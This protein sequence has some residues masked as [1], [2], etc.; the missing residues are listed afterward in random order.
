MADRYAT[1]D[2]DW[3]DASVWDG[4]ASL[5]GAGDTVRPN[6]FD[7][8]IDQSITVG[9][10]TNNASGAAAANGT[11]TLADGITINA[12]I[13]PNGTLGGANDFLISDTGDQII[14]GDFVNDGSNIYD[15]RGLYKNTTG[16][17]TVNGD[18]VGGRG[19]YSDCI[20]FDKNGGSIVVNGDVYGG[21]RTGGG[22][23]HGIEF[24][25]CPGTITIVGNV[26]CNESNAGIYHN[27]SGDVSI[28]GNITGAGPNKGG[29]S[30]LRDGVN[31]LVLGN[32]TA[33]FGGPGIYVSSTCTIEITGD[34][35]PSASEPAIAVA[36]INSTLTLI[37]EGA[38]NVDMTGQTAIGQYQY[39]IDPAAAITHAYRQNN[40][41]VAG[42]ERTLYT[43]N[44]LPVDYAPAQT[45]V[46]NGTTYNNGES[47]GS[48]VVPAAE[49][50]AYGVPVDAT[51]GTALLTADSLLGVIEPAGSG[52]RTITVHVTNATTEADI[53]AA[54]VTIKNADGFN[55]GKAPTD[56]NGNAELFV[57]DGPYTVI[58]TAENYV[59][60]SAAVTVSAD[61][62]VEIAL[63]PNSEPPEPEDDT[64]N[65]RSYTYD[66]D[67]QL[68]AGVTVYL[69]LVDYPSSSKGRI[70]V[71]GLR[72]YTSDESGH[73]AL[74]AV[75][76]G[77]TYAIWR[78]D[79][80]VGNRPKFRVPSGQ[81][82]TYTFPSLHEP[83]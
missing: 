3:S 49:S 30:I 42:D 23:A 52:D 55:K 39:L 6:G 57:D 34:L 46:R 64:V 2:G 29:V 62:T 71:N 60:N 78:G 61:A 81:T 59:N 51:V 21:T 31:V 18:V 13:H 19:L 11:F 77:A 7:V 8:V 63:T 47:T 27:G 56:A 68:E 16:T 36:L 4:G 73:V 28:T 43:L 17:L 72:T 14:N 38:L 1:K 76:P 41:G 20:Q 26:S 67:E 66:K 83:T 37:H 35:T 80:E 45:D 40:S 25:L 44:A 22:A 53:E 69:Q 58:A 9:I 24:A 33:G 75:V 65:A 70:G 32:V 79:V 82:T 50:V 5:P 54:S 15:G 74:G 48:L 10:L 12:D